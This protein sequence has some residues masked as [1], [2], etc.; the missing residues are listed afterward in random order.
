MIAVKESVVVRRL[1]QEIQ[2]S[3]P[4]AWATA[5]QAERGTEWT[6]AS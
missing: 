3:P 4:D 5:S 6:N 2:S 1:A